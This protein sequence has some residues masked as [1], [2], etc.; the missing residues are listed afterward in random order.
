[1]WEAFLFV[2]KKSLCIEN[3]TL[4]MT[5]LKTPYSEGGINVTIEEKNRVREMRMKGSTYADI[6]RKL[7]IN[8]STVRMYC[9]NNHLTDQDIE[10]SSICICCGTEI[11]QPKKG[12]RKVFCSERC[13]SA[14]RRSTHRLHETVYHHVCEECGT[15]FE[16]ISNR[17]QR[18]CSVQCYRKHRKEGAA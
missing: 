4:E 15:E 14:W 12:G 6:S 13:R 1:V 17:L 18:F 10:K 3:F 16:T 5:P 11:V 8:A 2:V 9:N 7:S